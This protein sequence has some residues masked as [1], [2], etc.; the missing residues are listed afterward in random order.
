MVAVVDE[1]TAEV[2]TVKVAVVLPAATV[3]EAG[4]V[5]E[6]ELELRETVAPPVGAAAVKVIV[7]WEV[8]PPVTVVGLRL[9]EL[10]AAAGGE[11]VS[12]AD[13]VTPL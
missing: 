10:K 8:D 9:T 4:T 1:D 7:P 6:A 11:M 2:E 5:A 12:V 3:T 13:C